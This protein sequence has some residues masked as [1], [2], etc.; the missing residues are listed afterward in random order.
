MFRF[1]KR[2]T[3]QLLYLLLARDMRLSEGREIGIDVGCGLMQNRPMFRTKRYFAI[4]LDAE[5][6]ATGRTKYPEAE[7]L[8]ARMEDVKDVVGDVVLCVQTFVNSQFL[9][10]NTLTAAEA[11]VRMTR[12]HGTLIFNISKRNMAYE[13]QIDTLLKGSFDT[14][15]K[16]PY[17]VLVGKTLGPLSPLVAFAALLLRPLR[18]GNSYDRIY[19]RC[20]GRR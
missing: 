6:L 1:S 19:Y 9:A 12:R 16:V 17:G 20:E 5:R 7:T 18:H 3:K 4:D 8:A 15:T 2:P 11:L 10:E 13:D 14:V